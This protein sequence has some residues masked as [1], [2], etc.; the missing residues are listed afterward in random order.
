MKDAAERP[1]TVALVRATTL[2]TLALAAGAWVVWPGGR[3]LAL[4]IVGG[5]VLAGLSTWAIG[6]AVAGLTASGG[7]RGR[8]AALVKFFT[9]HGIVA[10]VAYVMMVR[11]RLDPVGMLIGV[12]SIVVA[13]AVVATRSRR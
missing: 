13:A 4:G 12:T 3:H 9:R 10:L 1:L 8:G 11:W 2:T 6:S 7:R 5:G